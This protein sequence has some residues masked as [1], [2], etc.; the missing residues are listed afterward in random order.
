MTEPPELLP[1]NGDWSSY[2]DRLYEAFL[3]S[4]VRRTVQFRGWRVTAK[5]RPATRGKGYS[6][7]HTISEAPD[8][9]NRNE[10]DRIPDI[11]R[12]ERVCWIAWVIKNAG[13]EGFPWWETRRQNEIHVVIWA[14]ER[15]F[16]VVLVKRRDYY[17]LRTAYAEIK[18]HRRKTFERELAAFQKAT[19]G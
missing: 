1:F 15:D 13:S 8:R 2:E 9:D 3:D 4:F 17:M 14:R 11:R 7:W 6:F 18:P 10:N 5:Y 19:K 12:C 16:A